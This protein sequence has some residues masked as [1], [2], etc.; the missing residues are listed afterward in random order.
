MTAGRDPG[1]NF[2]FW[3]SDVLFGV[4]HLLLRSDVV[5]FSSEEKGRADDVLQVQFAPKA[6]ILAF[7][8]AVFLEQLIDRLEIPA[9][10]KVEG[11]LVPT[12]KYFG[13]L[14]I[15]RIVDMQEE[16]RRFAEIMLGWVHV[17][18]SLQHHFAAH[19]APA[20]RDEIL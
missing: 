1:D 18:P 2:V 13:L 17:L 11:M 20:R 8:E 12:C 3:R 19:Q 6:D 4:E 10:G 5:A 15:I 9:A 14:D 16:L 7:A